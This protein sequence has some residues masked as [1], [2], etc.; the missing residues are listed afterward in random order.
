MIKLKARNL[1]SAGAPEPLLLVVSAITAIQSMD[2]GGWCR[3]RCGD[4]WHDVAHSPD[5]VRDAISKVR[6]V[7]TTTS[8]FDAIF[9]SRGR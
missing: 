5:Q 8:L 4:Y 2:G 9:G 1:G 7:E 3:V 6:P